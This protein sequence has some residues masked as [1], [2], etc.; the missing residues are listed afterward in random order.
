MAEQRRRNYVKER[1]TITSKGQCTIPKAVR[2]HFALK[3]GDQ[4][5]FVEDETGMHIRRVLPQ[6]YK[7]QVAKW[8][9]TVPN[10]L[11]LTSDEMVREMR[12]D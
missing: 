3:P 10:P 11:G 2:D 4:I 9:G 8:R 7:D 6:D 1:A 12:G 5:D